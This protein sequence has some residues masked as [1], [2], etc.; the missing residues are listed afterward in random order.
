MKEKMKIKQTI[1]FLCV[2]ILVIAVGFFMVYKMDLSMSEYYEK[3]CG[4]MN[5]ELVAYSGCQPE[6]FTGERN[7]EK[8][9]G[10]YCKLNNGTEVDIT[11]RDAVSSLN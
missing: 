1:T 6:P 2:A 3:T 10:T 4:E 11:I 8:E 9:S 5:G 7:C